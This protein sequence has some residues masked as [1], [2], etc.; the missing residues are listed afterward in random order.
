M[1]TFLLG[2]LVLTTLHLLIEMLA[3][4]QQLADAVQH[5]FRD[6]AILEIIH[7]GG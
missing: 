3:L 7:L 6:P 2:L 5:F 1:T 4:V